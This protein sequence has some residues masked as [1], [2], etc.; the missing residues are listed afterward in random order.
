[1]QRGIVM[2][3]SDRYLA[4]LD[5][6][7]H[8]MQQ[9]SHLYQPT[10]FW[11]HA[12]EGVIQDLRTAG[13]T[14]FRSH[15]SAL[16]HYVPTYRKEILRVAPD[17]CR[18]LTAYAAEQ[19]AD[20]R[21]SLQAGHFLDGS[22]EAFADYRVVCAADT[23]AP[24]DLRSVSESEVGQ[25][26]EQMEFHDRRF[27][28]SFLNYLRALTF[29]KKTVPTDR[30]SS[31]L[32]I[33]GGFGTLGEIVLKAGDTYFYVDCDIPPLSL[34]ATYYLEQVFGSS[35]VA[36]YQLTRNMSTIDAAVLRKNYRAVVLCSWQLP[37]LTGV[38]DLFV[39]SMSFQEMEPDVVKNY[40][41]DV[42]RLRVKTVLIRNI[43]EGMKKAPPYTV[44]EP[45][46]SSDY[47]R[48]FSDCDLLAQD[49]SIYGEDYV[50]GFH[51]DVMIFGRR[52]SGAHAA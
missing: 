38:F 9:V 7:L 52:L 24:P 6:M 51:S 50:D 36:G 32:E 28:K 31:V 46:K 42:R 12:S 11:R 27:S 21:F 18:F 2:E 3:D 22:L 40:V 20:K 4:L 19:F 37:R 43:R 1:M 47:P 15:P 48:Y 33:G 10:N 29:L 49:S 41:D 26:A 5:L 14:D 34:I 25:P 30:I 23:S 16:R 13:L 17:L 35:A 8:D 45:V 44:D 39:N